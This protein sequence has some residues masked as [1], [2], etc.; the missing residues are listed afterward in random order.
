MGCA[1]STGQQTLYMYN[2]GAR[3]VLKGVSLVTAPHKRRSTKWG[4]HRCSLEERLRLFHRLL[5][6]ARTEVSTEL[7]LITPS[8]QW[9]QAFLG[10][11]SV[12][13][14][15]CA[16]SLI[17]ASSKGA[18]TRQQRGWRQRS[19]LHLRTGRLTS[20][21]WA[22][23]RRQYYRG[24]FWEQDLGLKWAAT[25]TGP[26]SCVPRLLEWT[27]QCILTYI[28]HITRVGFL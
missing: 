14:C 8:A 6:V 10:Y 15:A 19:Q 9:S 2:H 26:W 12:F 16:H 24:Q 20:T 28:T 4:R 17:G 3:Q 23:M 1:G 11:K 18:D 27:N 22:L 25:G 21:H 5:G 7:G 13:Q